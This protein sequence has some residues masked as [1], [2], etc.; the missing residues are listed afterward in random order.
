MRQR[1]HRLCTHAAQSTVAYNVF[2]LA[3]AA[4]WAWLVIAVFG[5]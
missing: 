2:Y 4:G 1:W 3:L 5:R